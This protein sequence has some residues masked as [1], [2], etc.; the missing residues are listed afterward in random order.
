MKKLSIFVGALTLTT[1]MFAQDLT[2]KKGENFLPETGDWALGIDA[3]P[4]LQYFG[5]FLGSRDT[6]NFAPTFGWATGNQ[7]IVGIYFV[8]EKMAYRGALRIGMGSN[9]QVNIVDNRSDVDALYPALPATVENTGKMGMSN[10]GLS[11][12]LEW[13]KGTTRLQGFYGA[14]LGIMTSGMKGKYEYGNALTQVIAPVANENVNITAADGFDFNGDLVSDNLNAGVGADANGARV[15]ESKT[16][17]FGFGL[18]GFV[19][20]EYF[21]LPKLSIGGQFGWGL[22]MSSTKSSM[23]TESEGI[24]NGFEAK[25]EQ[26]PATGKT[27][28]FGLDTDNNNNVFGNAGQI[29]IV[30][31]F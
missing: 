29:N 18:R 24:V 10:I 22:V 6:T 4:F 12:G 16:S 5:N 31:H 9:T 11:G 15:L 21:V 3:T 17:T 14:E 19:G 25:G 2:S 8:S 1:S 30:F 7:T 28:S 13:R 26:E 23:K 20:V 27:S